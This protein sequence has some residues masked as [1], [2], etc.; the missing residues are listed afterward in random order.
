MKVIR[1]TEQMNRIPEAVIPSQQL[2]A[3]KSDSDEWI[4]ATHGRTFHFA[5]RFLSP[6]MRHNVVHGMHS[7]AR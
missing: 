4:L 3:D 6:K 1:N 2:P 7:F 5:A